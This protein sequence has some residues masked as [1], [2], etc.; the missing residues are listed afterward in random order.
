MKGPG[1]SFASLAPI[2]VVALLLASNG[3]AAAPGAAWKVGGGEVRVVCPLTVGGSF[4]ARTISLTGK[5]SLTTAHPPA[6]A[7]ELVVDLRTLDT[8][9]DLRSEHMR[10]QYLEVGRGPGF[11]AAV[12]SDLALGDVDVDTFRGRT[13]FSGNLQL[14]GAKKAIRGDATIR[15]EGGAVRVEASFPIK[16]ADFGIPSP[17]YLGVGVRSEVQVKVALTS[18]PE[19]P[20]GSP[21]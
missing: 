18:T 15:R 9:I 2:G 1:F 3:R 13:T 14:H 17:Q 19:T 10:T 20:E 16:L 7:G 6:F 4:E 5:L 21:R 11:E 12:L 8:G